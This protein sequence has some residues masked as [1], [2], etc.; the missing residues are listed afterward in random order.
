MKTAKPDDRLDELFLDLPQPA[1]IFSPTVHVRESGDSCIVGTALPYTDGRVMFRGRLGLELRLEQGQAA[2][3]VALVQALAMLKTHLG[4]LNNV[5]ACVQLT[6]YIAASAD[7]KDHLKVLD[8]ASA[9]LAE[10]FGETTGAHT[11]T[12]VGVSS[13]PEG[14]CVM[15]TLQV[16]LT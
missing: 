8:H 16:R 15:L 11:R 1:R 14:A 6:G 3:R 13:L 4:S 7:F 9:L 10:V 5:K 2:A 12:A